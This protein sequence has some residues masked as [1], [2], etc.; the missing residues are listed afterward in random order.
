MKFTPENLML[1][2][3]GR[4]VITRKPFASHPDFIETN[5]LHVLEVEG[6]RRYCIGAFPNRF[7]VRIEKI[8]G[9]LVFEAFATIAD[10]LLE[11]GQ[12]GIK[13]LNLYTI[14]Q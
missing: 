1:L 8:K 3:I 14:Q 7:L 2:P 9:K 6:E 12:M 5:E 13:K 11:M 10:N 4:Y